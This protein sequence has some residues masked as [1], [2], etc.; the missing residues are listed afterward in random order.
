MKELLMMRYRYLLF[1]TIAMFVTW[2]TNDQM[3]VAQSSFGCGYT[4]TFDTGNFVTG[5]PDDDS[6]DP[7]LLP[8]GWSAVILPSQRENEGFPNTGDVRWAFSSNERYCN[9]NNLVGTGNALCVSSDRAAVREGS[10]P[11]GMGYNTAIFSPLFE[12]SNVEEVTISYQLNYQNVSGQDILRFVARPDGSS[13]VDIDEFMVDIPDIEEFELGSQ[14]ITRTISRDEGGIGNQTGF[15]WRYYDLGSDFSDWYVQIDDISITCE[16]STFAVDGSITGLENGDVVTVTMTSNTE[17]IE[18]TTSG[19]EFEFADVLPGTYMIVVSGYEIEAD[20]PVIIPTDGTQ[21]TQTVALTVSKLSTP[22]PVPP[23]PE[24][25]DVPT[26]TPE[27]TNTPI[28]PTEAPT[29]EPTNTPIPPTETPMT[30]PTVTMSPTEAY[31]VTGEIFI[32]DLVFSPGINDVQLLFEPEFEGGLSEE[33]FLDLPEP[34]TRTIPFT[35]T[36]LQEGD[37]MLNVRVFIDGEVLQGIAITPQNISVPRSEPIFLQLADATALSVVTNSI[38]AGEIQ[39][40]PFVA[41][42]GMVIGTTAAVKSKRI[43]NWIGLR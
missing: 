18:T 21:P 22:T 26:S 41:V 14:T 39:Y 23:T 11:P 5:Y 42:G 10:Q 32:T 43:A 3:V 24:P 7:S 33:E 6:N 2:H 31:T 1:L 17:S 19:D 16:Y 34:I 35:V 30:T 38:G 29:L 9:I 8:E 36:N 4:E 37:Y 27:P 13:S 15:A 20:M 28:P 40:L 12:T 25:T